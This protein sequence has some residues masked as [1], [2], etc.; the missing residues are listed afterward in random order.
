L[1]VLIAIAVIIFVLR[2]MV[3]SYNKK[4]ERRVLRQHENKKSSH[5][6]GRG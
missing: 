2:R 5:K 1:I 3:R 4:I 6:Q